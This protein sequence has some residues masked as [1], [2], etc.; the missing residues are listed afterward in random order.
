MT[1]LIRALPIDK[2][3]HPVSHA[4]NEFMRIVD[5]IKPKPANNK[6]STDTTETQVERQLLHKLLD[7]LRLPIVAS[8]LFFVLNTGTM[9]NLILDMIPYSKKGPLH[10]TITKTFIFA[11]LIFG[12]V[13]VV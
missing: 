12:L 9:N 4:E 3:E 5:R 13:Y 1:D 6:V 10:L 2:D 7:D 8:I 11:I